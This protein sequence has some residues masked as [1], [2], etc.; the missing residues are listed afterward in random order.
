MTS[1][2]A[3]CWWRGCVQAAC[4]SF[5]FFSLPRSPALKTHT[6]RPL[7]SRVRRQERV[8]VLCG[9]GARV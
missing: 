9:G 8:L 4:V 6:Q 3:A 5:R 2:V 7:I 1:S